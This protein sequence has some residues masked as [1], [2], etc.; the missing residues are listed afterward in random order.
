MFRYSSGFSFLN[1]DLKKYHIYLDP[2]DATGSI[3]TR[4]STNTT[5]ARKKLSTAYIVRCEMITKALWNIPSLSSCNR[6]LEHH[7][8]LADV[9][10]MP[11][12]M[13]PH[14]IS[15]ICD[16]FGFIL[17]ELCTKERFVPLVETLLENEELHFRHLLMMVLGDLTLSVG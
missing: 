4:S 2:F 6:L 5:N 12:F 11:E 14:F 15:S 13:I 16:K 7:H 1:L 8:D 9:S 17:A 3:S 10:G